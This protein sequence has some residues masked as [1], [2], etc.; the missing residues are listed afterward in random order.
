MFWYNGELIDGDTL[1]LN[2]NEPGLI[3]G[4]TVFTTLR[5]YHQS[6][7]Y[8]LTNWKAHCDRLGNSLITF[9]WQMPNWKRLRQGAELLL[10]LFPV[11]RLVIFA[12]GREW[13]IGRYLPED[14]EERQQQGI[15]AWLAD[16]PLF[17]RSLAAY[18]T[19]NYL[20]G[21]LALQQ[22]Q[23]L[24]AKEAILI[25]NQGNWLETSTGNLWGWKD[26]YWWTPPLD[27]EILP[28]IV[29]SQLLLSLQDQGQLVKEVVWHQ[30]FVEDLKAIA[31]SNSVMEVIPFGC[32]LTQEGKSTLDPCHPSLKQLRSYFQG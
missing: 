10:P 19:G 4:A 3:Y 25:D 24:G 31:Y 16:E 11:L 9:G 8:S 15:T 30:N 32:I 2:I 5:I 14:L 17:R 7:D 18:K 29:R 23:K 13:I 1:E 22:G 12:D 20:G 26:G 21:W 27:G 28:G 6:L